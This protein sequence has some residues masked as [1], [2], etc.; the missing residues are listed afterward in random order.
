MSLEPHER[1]QE[2]VDGG[3]RELIEPGLVELKKP[4]FAYNDSF[5]SSVFNEKFDFFFARSVWTHVSKTQI[6]IMLDAFARDA[7]DDGIFLTSYHPAG[8]HSRFF[9]SVPSWILSGFR[10][11]E[12]M[13]EEYVSAAFHGFEWIQAQCAKRGLVAEE[14]KPG[15]Y[16]TQQW[17]MITKQGRSNSRGL[18]ERSEASQR[19]RASFG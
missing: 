13:G 14:L 10:R 17:L 11:P 2:V 16:N 3:I 1:H 18:W 5:D 9:Q 12:Y 6:E 15:F 4:H 8:F 7:A 19:L